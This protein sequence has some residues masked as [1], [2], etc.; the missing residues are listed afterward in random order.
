MDPLD[1]RLM[2]EKRYTQRRTLTIIRK[3]FGSEGIVNSA[4]DFIS[5][6]ICSGPA[7]LAIL[8]LVWSV[9]GL[10]FRELELLRAA[11]APLFSN[12]SGPASI[13]E[14]Y[15]NVY[16][17]RIGARQSAAIAGGKKVREDATV[18]S[19]TWQTP[20]LSQLLH[21]FLPIAKSVIADSQQQRAVFSFFLNLLSPF[22]SIKTSENLHCLLRLDL[23]TLGPRFEERA[24]N[25][26]C[27]VSY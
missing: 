12:K 15:P 10:P 4:A 1:F 17:S 8:E 11:T 24:R 21:S 26:K 25:I 18:S 19:N 7:V 23:I 22:S 13:Q 16:D 9:P 5:A 27:Y 20:Y 14:R 6:A 3:T 2:K